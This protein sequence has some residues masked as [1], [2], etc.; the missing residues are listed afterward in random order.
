[1]TILLEEMRKQNTG[2]EQNSNLHPHPWNNLQPGDLACLT[3]PEGIL[4]KAVQIGPDIEDIQSALKT[5]YARNLSILRVSGEALSLETC[6]VNLAIIE[7]LSQREKEKSD[8]KEQS[9]IFHRI[10]SSE[11][12]LGVNLQSS[13]P[14]DQLFDKRK[15]RDGNEDVPK[16][17]LVQGRA[18]IGKTTLCKKLVH[19]HQAGL[20]SDRFDVVI[21][22]PLRELK[23][24]KSRTLESLLHEKYFSRQGLNN[25]GAAL[26]YALATRAQKG[27]VLFILD[28]LDEIIA[29]TKTSEGIVL[30]NFL[31]DLLNQQHVVITSRPSGLDK[32]LLPPIDL[33]LET[34]GFSQQNVN[35]FLAKV[36]EP[37]AA[38]TIQD[39]IRQTPLIQGL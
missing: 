35:D 18:G 14:L 34:I 22:L 7:A 27:K 26:A 21:W 10:P 9:A 39:F 12:V 32:S 30:K 38:A 11:A 25:K 5:Y 20:F 33:E 4:L 1:A 28:G 3:P 17:I 6:F 2:L 31:A 15:L 19:A 29:D 24:F 13:I 23:A 8:L 37:E 36:L 16:R